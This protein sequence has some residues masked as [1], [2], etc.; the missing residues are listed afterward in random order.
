MKAEWIIDQDV[1]NNISKVIQNNI[2]KAIVQK[3]INT[4][5]K[6]QGIDLSQSNIW[7]K[8][9]G[10]EITTQQKSGF[11]SPVDL[12]LKSS[13]NPVLDYDKCKKLQ[14]QDIS[15]ELSNGHL[16]NNKRIASFLIR[17]IN[18]LE[19]GE[20]NIL[21]EKLESL[22]KDH[23]KQEE[24]QVV[25]Y[26][27]SGLY[28]GLGL[29]QSRNFIQWLGLSVFEIPIDSR[30]LKVLK[31]CKFNFVPGASALQDEVTYLFLES[32]IQKACE[33][34]DIKPCILDACFF[35]SFEKEEE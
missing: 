23:T 32:G 14:E 3:R 16:R 26:L 19:S 22:N 2:H 11:G 24:I 30:E 12:F 28:P 20:W 27:H 1:L 10:C 13:N 35:A 9:V 34:L 4:N 18:L 25:Q 15:E 31:K 6:K 17:I 7:K 5:I 33:L 21:I 8:I 29:K